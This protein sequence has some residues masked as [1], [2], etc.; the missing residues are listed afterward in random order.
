MEITN[1]LLSESFS[2]QYSGKA[3][4]CRMDD[5]EK[6]NNILEFCKDIDEVVC[7]DQA[8]L[9]T[10]VEEGI[11][12]YEI[13]YG[14]KTGKSMDGTIFL[15]EMLNKKCKV[16]ID[17]SEYIIMCSCGPFDGGVGTIQEYIC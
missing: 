2:Y 9:S 7:Y 10:E 17:E 6:L 14:I 16:K 3:L 15:Q 1:E 5:Q 8:L 12:L 4:T 13:I 11:C